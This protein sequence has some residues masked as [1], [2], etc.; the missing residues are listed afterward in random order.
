MVTFV[1]AEIAASGSKA[2][3]AKAMALSQKSQ[4]KLGTDAAAGTIGLAWHIKPDGTIWHNG[5]TGGYH[6]YVAFRP[7]T[8]L[9]VVV[10]ASGST[11]Y[12]DK[13]G[14]AALAA[15]AGE[16][17]PTTLDLPPPDVAVPEKTLETY[18]GTYELLPKFEISISRTGGKL[19]G[20]ATGQPK[21]RLHATSQT[22]FTIPVVSATVTFEVD[23]KHKVTA[24]V[25]HQGGADHRAPRK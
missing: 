7:G 10:L 6:S 2:P 15:I 8:K 24:L 5:A 17:V 1:K 4:R 18:V 3:L 20:Q 23:A 11:S 13:L 14:A 12:V 19:F 9:G 22:A 25:L 21:F 16:A